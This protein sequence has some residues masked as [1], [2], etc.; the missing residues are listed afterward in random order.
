MSNPGL[1]NIFLAVWSSSPTK[2]QT[3]GNGTERII[4]FHMAA[5]YLW[6]YSHMALNFYNYN[7]YGH[8]AKQIDTEEVQKDEAFYR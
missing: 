8:C 4:N 2:A 5:R 3:G 1:S 7:D 6:S